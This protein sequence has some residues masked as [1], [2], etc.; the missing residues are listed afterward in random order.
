MH[1]TS[2][3]WL[4]GLT[5]ATAAGLLA[6]SVAARS[7]ARLSIADRVLPPGPGREAVLRMCSDCHTADTIAYQRHS[8]D[9]WGTIIEDMRSRGAQGDDATAGQVKLYLARAF[10][11]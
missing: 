7:Q 5:L 11:R 8:A 6:T 1:A 9:E 10:G 3:P 2:S 4:R